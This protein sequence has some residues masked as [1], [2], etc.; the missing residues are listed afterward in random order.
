M[1]KELAN[2]GTYTVKESFDMWFQV[3]SAKYYF[4]SDR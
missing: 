4:I 2:D 1:L 3:T